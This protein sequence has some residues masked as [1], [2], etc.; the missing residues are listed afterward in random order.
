MHAQHSYTHRDIY[1]ACCTLA[2]EHSHNH[3][4]LNVTRILRPS[5]RFVSDKK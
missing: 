4:T 2:P 5:G 1:V 3:I